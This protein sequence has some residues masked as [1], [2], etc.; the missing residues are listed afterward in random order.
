[1]QSQKLNDVEIIEG[2]QVKISNKLA[3]LENLMMMM[4]MM[5]IRMMLWTSMG[6]GEVLE[7]I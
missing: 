3:V 4:M 5:M 1:M 2:C 6:L 7:R